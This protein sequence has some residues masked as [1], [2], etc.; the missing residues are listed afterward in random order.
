M[1]VR[2]FLEVEGFFH[3]T[4]LVHVKK[5]SQLKVYLAQLAQLDVFAQ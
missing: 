3:V 2:G 1:K 5:F 4:I